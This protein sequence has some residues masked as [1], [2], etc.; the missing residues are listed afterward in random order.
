MSEQEWFTIS[1]GILLHSNTTHEQIV[2]RFKDKDIVSI[3]DFLHV[4]KGLHFKW[5]TRWA[6]LKARFSSR[7]YLNM[8]YQWRR[9]VVKGVLRT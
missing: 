5:N 9:D 7:N 1:V 8:L 2:E 3:G 4:E 6:R